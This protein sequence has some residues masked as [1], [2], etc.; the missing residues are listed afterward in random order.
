M[1]LV[2]DFIEFSFRKLIFPIE[3]PRGT[4][5]FTSFYLS[6]DDYLEERKIF[7]FHAVQNGQLEIHPLFRVSHNLFVVPHAVYGDIFF[8]V[9]LISDSCEYLGSSKEVA[10]DSKFI[11]LFPLDNDELNH[12]C[13]YHKFFFVGYVDRS[14]ERVVEELF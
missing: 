5:K 11:R 6:F 13:E 10:K 14:I 3:R 8:G 4:S 1:S 9:S 12:L 7:S 2:Y